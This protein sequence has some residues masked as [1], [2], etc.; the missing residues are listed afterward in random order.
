LNYRVL[1]AIVFSLIIAIELLLLLNAPTPTE[2]VITGKRKEGSLFAPTKQV[3]NYEAQNS[4]YTKYGI[5]IGATTLVGAIVTFSLA[6][7]N[8]ERSEHTQ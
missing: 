4:L 3:I 5:I 8:K 1:S 6:N 7:K 2:S